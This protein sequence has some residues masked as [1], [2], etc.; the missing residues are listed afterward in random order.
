MGQLTDAMEGFMGK[1]QDH[2]APD[3]FAVRPLPPPPFFVLIGHA[4]SFTPY[5][6]DTPRPSPRT[7]RTRRVLHPVLIGSPR[8]SFSPQP[9]PLFPLSVVRSGGEAGMI[10]AV[11]SPSVLSLPSPTPLTPRS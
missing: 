4:A 11:T 7:N 1:V 3:A 8:N 5:Q 9:S 6:S 2:K 10:S